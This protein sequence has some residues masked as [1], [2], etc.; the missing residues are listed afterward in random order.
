[1]RRGLNA[2]IFLRLFTQH[3]SISLCSDISIFDFKACHDYSDFR[4]NILATFSG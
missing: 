2:P 4:A 1:M 3:H